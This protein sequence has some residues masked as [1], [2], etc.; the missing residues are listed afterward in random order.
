MIRAIDLRLRG[1]TYEAIGRRLGLSRQR[2]QQLVQPSREVRQLLIKWAHERCQQ[3]G[4]SIGQ[5]GEVHHRQ[6]PGLVAERYNNLENLEYLCLPCHMKS[7]HRHI[8]PH[9]R[10]PLNLE[11][12]CSRPLE[13]GD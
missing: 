4:V 11:A 13:K 5:G 10:Q 8:C 7:H 3:C 2:V 1:Q 6:A 9:C 12:Q